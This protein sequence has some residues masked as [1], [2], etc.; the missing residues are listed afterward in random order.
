NLQHLLHGEW[1]PQQKIAISVVGIGRWPAQHIG[2]AAGKAECPCRSATAAAK[3]VLN[4]VHVLARYVKAETEVVVLLRPIQIGRVLPC[5]I[6]PDDWPVR[7]V[8]TQ[9][10]E[11]RDR[12]LR[13]ASFKSPWPVRAWNPQEVQPQF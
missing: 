12:E 10:G 7:R 4:A 13:P 9:S 3:L 11:I 1:V 6:V 8:Q 2:T 5:R